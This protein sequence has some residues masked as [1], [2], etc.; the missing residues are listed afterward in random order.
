MYVLED[1][2]AIID[3]LYPK[4]SKK[5]SYKWTFEKSSICILDTPDLKSQWC[6]YE[7]EC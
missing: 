5:L 7:K 2:K 4:L 1:I 3:I 6:H